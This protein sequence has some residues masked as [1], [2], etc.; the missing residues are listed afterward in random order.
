M[1]D[2]ID[3]LANGFID[4]RVDLVYGFPGFKSEAVLEKISPDFKISTNERVAYGEA[5]GA[6]I[7]GKRSLVG[8]KN[9]GLNIAS[10]AYAHSI[11]AGV[12]AGMVVLVTDDV[13]VWGSQ[14]SQDT[15]G[16]VDYYQGFLYEP[17]SLQAAYDFARYSF[18]LSEK[19]DIPIVM[20]ITNQALTFTGKYTRADRI[21]N[22]HK[23]PALNNPL[24]YVVHPYY[25]RQQS[26]RLESKRK[27][28]QDTA[29]SMHTIISIDKHFSGQCAVTSFG[30][31]NDTIS[32]VAACCKLK[33][34]TI[35]V[36]DSTL[37]GHLKNH[38]QNYII[39]SGN[40]YLYNKARSVDKCENLVP[41][42]PISA[43][44]GTVEFKKWSRYESL[45][46]IIHETKLRHG[47]IVIADIAQFTVESTDTVDI[48]LS[49]GASLPIAIGAYQASKI[50]VIVVVGDCSFN[51]EGVQVLYEAVR[52]DIT[53]HVFIIDNG[54][55]WCTGCQK[56]ASPIRDLAFPKTI[57]YARFRYSTNVLANIENRIH[58]VMTSESG[59]TLTHITVPIGPVDR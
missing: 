49:M 38:S 4:G 42:N 53:M 22:L 40:P 18:E 24:K 7:G 2:I 45:F 34:N 46:T 37:S 15:R 59:I 44:A 10:D 56:N 57:N 39:E 29:N 20:R 50:P 31:C 23:D 1:S 28:F 19:L 43:I 16:L 13:E 14:E 48:A 54:V 32:H 11:I 36:P 5:Y 12:N 9:I 51:H 33:I 17:D 6:S 21:D 25:F 26:L 41:L 47:A 3:A 35:P 27:L 58:K 52:R 30:F 8:F 55:S